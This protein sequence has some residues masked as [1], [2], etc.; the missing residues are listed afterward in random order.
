M[1]RRML[2]SYAMKLRCSALQLNKRPV[3]PASNSGA[4]NVHFKCCDS[5]RLLRVQDMPEI[6]L[7]ILL[8]VKARFP[9]HLFF[10]TGK[11]EK[12]I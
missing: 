1:S 8:Y 2:T 10:I 9:C 12:L 7:L 4:A 5:T 11:Y 3:V 6:S